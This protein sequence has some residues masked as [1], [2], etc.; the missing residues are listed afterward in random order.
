MLGWKIMKG[1]QWADSHIAKM[2]YVGK[3]LVQNISL[4]LKASENDDRPT[5]RKF[6]DKHGNVSWMETGNSYQ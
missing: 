1:K 5:K 2:C 3:S 4:D 6:I